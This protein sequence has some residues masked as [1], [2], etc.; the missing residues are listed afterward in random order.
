MPHAHQKVVPLAGAV[1]HHNVP[2]VVFVEVHKRGAH[3][4]FSNANEKG[5]S[6]RS[7]ITS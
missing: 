4:I 6:L 2:I 3:R 5:L 7:I 1:R